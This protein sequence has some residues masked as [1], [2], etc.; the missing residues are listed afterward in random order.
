[1]FSRLLSRR[2]VASIAKSHESKFQITLVVRKLQIHDN[3]VAGTGTM[4]KKKLEAITSC[5][6]KVLRVVLF[7]QDHIIA[8]AKKDAR[9]CE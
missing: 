9:V 4:K 8:P 6:S 7:E 2:S 5:L 1:M 3:R